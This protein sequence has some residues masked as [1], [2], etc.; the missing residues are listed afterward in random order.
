MS[1]L[2]ARKL[3]AKDALEAARKRKDTRGQHEA[4]ERLKAATTAQLR[5]E[6]KRPWWSFIVSFFDA[7]GMA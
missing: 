6:V 5:R 3:A 4:S 7:A 2:L 1:R